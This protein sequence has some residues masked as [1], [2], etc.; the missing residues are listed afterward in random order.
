MLIYLNPCR[1]LL[2][3]KIQHEYKKTAKG[4]VILIFRGRAENKDLF[5]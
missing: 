5:M 3:L 2:Q 4:L 1:P